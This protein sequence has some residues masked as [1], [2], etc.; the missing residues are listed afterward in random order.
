MGAA[1]PAFDRLFL[2]PELLRPGVKPISPV[3]IDRSNKLGST[4]SYY[5][6]LNG[7]GLEIVT[8]RRLTVGA[9]GSYVTDSNGLSLRGSGTAACASIPLDL[10]SYTSCTVSFWM[11]WDAYANNDDLALEY[12]ENFLTNSGFL[13][14]PNSG[15]P[16]SGFFQAGVGSPGK[17]NNQYWTRPTSGEWHH[18]ALTF[19]RAVGTS[20]STNLYVDG[21]FKTKSGVAG[22]QSDVT[23]NFGNNYLY[24]FSRNNTSLFGAGKMFGLTI[25]GQHIMTADEVFYEFIDP[26]QILKPAGTIALP[27]AAGGGS[28]ALTGTVTA[29]ITESDIVTGGKT[30]ILTLTGDTWVAAGATFDAQ[31]QNIIDG[32]DSAQAEATG[33]DAVVKAGLTPSDVVRT[34]DTVCTITLPA[35]ATYDITAQETITATIPA[36][37][38]TGA[39]PI[40]AAPTFTVDYTAGG[41]MPHWGRVSQQS[42]ILG[43]M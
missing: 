30:I 40:V 28:S 41:F 9:G 23:N 7:S 37:V 43:A 1:H 14:D 42:R 18:Y 35:L 36:A 11:Y 27:I 38:L 20:Q 17:A 6:P 31:R 25:R 24:I 8:G 13:I 32:L 29:S 3:E 19:D 39:S 26:Y 33:W 16:S 4:I 22:Y 34:S 21:V 10:S 2:A 12:G 15:Y 5:L